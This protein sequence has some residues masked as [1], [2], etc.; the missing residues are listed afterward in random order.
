MHQEWKKKV[1]NKNK[2]TSLYLIIHTMLLVT[3]IN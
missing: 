3:V 2:Y 1:S